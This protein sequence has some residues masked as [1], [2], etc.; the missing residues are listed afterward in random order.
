MGSCGSPFL[1][2]HAQVDQEV[3][4]SGTFAVMKLGLR[5]RLLFLS[6][7]LGLCFVGLPG[8]GQS[9]VGTTMNPRDTEQLPPDSLLISPDSNLADTVSHPIAS[10]DTI[11]DTTNTP[12]LPKP[13]P[14]K[15]IQTA[16]PDPL[17]PL[18]QL[19]V[20]R[21]TWMAPYVPFVQEVAVGIDYGRLVMNI[22][23]QP[24]HRYE[25]S[26]GI[27]FRKHIQLSADLGYKKL[28]PKHSSSNKS[29][30]EVAGLY[31]RI[32]LDY[33]TRYSARDNLYAGLRYGR[34][35]FTNSTKPD[36]THTKAIRQALT[37]SWFEL[38]VGSDTRLF[39]KL[40]LYA[41]LALRLGILYNFQQFK[42]AKNYVIP[43]YGRT[44]NKLVVDLSLY[45]Q[46]RLSFLDRQISF[47]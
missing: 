47:N 2:K 34:S 36:N 20:K 30:Y 38:V 23:T 4:I 31:G 37:A 17:P 46:Y 33:L 44:T 5:H 21:P 28:T 15:P 7:L 43:G 41:G 39:P 19:V 26:L 13:K 29:K 25:G 16:S 32:G 42:P 14:L 45:I 6:I 27:L 1:L 3:H 8:F 24:A 10:T 18:D 22:F 11:A 9:A 35:H 12:L 40:G